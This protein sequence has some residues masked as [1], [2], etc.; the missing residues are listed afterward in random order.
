VQTAHDAPQ[1]ST[2]YDLALTG[3]PTPRRRT[4][5]K[6]QGVPCLGLAWRAAFWLFRS[7]L[8]DCL[9]CC[10]RRIFPTKQTPRCR[11]SSSVFRAPPT[12]SAPLTASQAAF[13]K[14]S[15]LVSFLEAPPRETHT[16]ENPN[17][18][19]AVGIFSCDGFDCDLGQ[20]ADTPSRT[21]G[22]GPTTFKTALGNT[23]FGTD[24]CP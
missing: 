6:V 9:A 21:R 10:S 18:Y 12:Q 16:K 13:G 3:N 17:L 5:E 4:P 2:I 20:A 22:R 7:R 14:G 1:P 15:K 8:I 19:A 23:V 11:P 24:I